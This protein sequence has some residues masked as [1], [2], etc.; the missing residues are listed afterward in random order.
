MSAQAVLPGGN[1]KNTT[2]KITKTDMAFLWQT[3]PF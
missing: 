1:R 3:L 2:T